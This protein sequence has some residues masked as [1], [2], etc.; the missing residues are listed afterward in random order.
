MRNDHE[1]VLSSHAAGAEVCGILACIDVPPLARVRNFS[2]CL[3][4]IG[5]VNME[6]LAF[7]L[8]IT[9]NNFGIWVKCD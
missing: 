6:S 8:D 4:T 9:E 1:P 2:D 7:V 3:N 5:D